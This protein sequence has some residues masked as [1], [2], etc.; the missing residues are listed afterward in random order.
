MMV[1]GECRHRRWRSCYDA[2]TLSHQ[3]IQL[4]DEG[5]SG[6]S[7]LA[8]TSS[9]LVEAA[10]SLTGSVPAG[11]GCMLIK[12]QLKPFVAG[13]ILLVDNSRVDECTPLFQGRMWPLVVGHILPDDEGVVDERIP[14]FQGGMRRAVMTAGRVLPGDEGIVGERIPLFQGG[15]LVCTRHLVYTRHLPSSKRPG[16]SPA[17]VTPS[18]ETSEARILP[19][20]G[21]EE[22]EKGWIRPFSKRPGPLPAGATPST[23]TSEARISP[24]FGWEEG[25]KGGYKKNKRL[26]PLPAGATPSTETSRFWLGGGGER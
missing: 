26:G 7:L 13:S 6:S 22:G 17:R 2:V 25:E 24:N 5:T 15:H 12:E 8:D 10:L 19:K 1:I 16:P 14:L 23:E 11:A 3:A 18:T 9:M 21:W 4:G 20:S